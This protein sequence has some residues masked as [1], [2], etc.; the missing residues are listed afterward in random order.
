MSKRF[1]AVDEESLNEAWD[2]AKPGDVITVASDHTNLKELALFTEEENEK[3][4]FGGKRLAKARWT[5]PKP[6]WAD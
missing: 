2:Q 6:S 3:A 5:F 4:G 1:V